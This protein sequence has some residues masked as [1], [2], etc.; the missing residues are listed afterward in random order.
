MNPNYY[1]VYLEN[2]YT[3][4]E[5][6]AFTLTFVIRDSNNNIVEDLSGFKFAF[7]LDSGALEVDKKDS[8][9]SGG[10]TGQIAVNGHKVFVYF[11]EDDTDNF[12]DTWA[13]GI[14][15]MT[16]KENNKRYTVFRKKF[17]FYKEIL[18]W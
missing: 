1:A 5:N 16:N 14:L 9:Y 4:I 6:D 12:E 17:S 15:Q 2:K 13:D 10:G 18:D 11:D 8:N 7:T 3:L